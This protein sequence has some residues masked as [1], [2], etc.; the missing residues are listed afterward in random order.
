M[1]EGLKAEAVTDADGRTVVVKR[2]SV[3]DRMRIKRVISSD[4]L[5]KPLWLQDMMVIASVLS[6][7]GVPRAPLT[8]VASYEA[9]GDMIGQA[10]MDAAQDFLAR[11]SEPTPEGALAAAGN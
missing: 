2:L 3:S 11:L 7:D 10:G 8:D 6:I 1:A 9:A 5:D 4:M